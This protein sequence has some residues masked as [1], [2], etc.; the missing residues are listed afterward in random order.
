MFDGYFG[1]DGA[2]FNDF[3]AELGDGYKKWNWGRAA[4]EGSR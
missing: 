2:F 1:D 4:E 3:E